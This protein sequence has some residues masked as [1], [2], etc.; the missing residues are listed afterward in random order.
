MR[1]IVRLSGIVMPENHC[2]ARRAARGARDAHGS[3][4]GMRR[5][6][7]HPGIAVGRLTKIRASGWRPGRPLLALD[8][9]RQ[10]TDTR[11]DCSRP[12]ALRQNLERRN[13]RTI[14]MILKTLA[15]LVPFSQGRRY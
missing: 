8:S 10:S 11:Q 2:I 9:A 4:D 15:G 1:A 3:R 7:N 6:I 13:Q 5:R 14:S 12:G